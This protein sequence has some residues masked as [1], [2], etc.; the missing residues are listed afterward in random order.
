M[1]YVHY[2]NGFSFSQPT[3]KEHITKS[4]LFRRH[5]GPAKGPWTP[6]SE[7]KNFTI[8]VDGFM[9]IITNNYDVF[10]YM[11]RQWIKTSIFS[12]INHIFTIWSS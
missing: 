4:F 9:N 6:D 7:I 3:V 11:P 8:Y 12:K 2:S 1:H 10:D 5:I